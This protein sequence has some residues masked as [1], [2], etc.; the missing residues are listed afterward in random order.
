MKN[1]G[2]TLIEVLLATVILGAGII[3]IFTSISPCL[4]MITASKRIQEVQWVYSLGL[5]K[6][7]ITDFEEVEDLVVEDDSELALEESTLGEGYVFSR[8]VDE[9][10]I[11][12]GSVDDGLYTVRT[13]VKWGEGAD[14]FEE[15]I[16]LVW[17]KDG[18]EYTP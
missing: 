12:E 6:H 13:R 3:A 9:K 2:F 17:K 5:L 16:Q 10:I 11:E 18:G 15:I 8:S 7:P 4:A 14:G 1:N